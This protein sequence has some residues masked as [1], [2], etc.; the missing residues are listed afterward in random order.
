MKPTSYNGA[1]RVVNLINK[2]KANSDIVDSHDRPVH[3]EANEFCSSHAQAKRILIKVAMHDEGLRQRLCE[4]ELKERWIL[5][6]G[7]GVVIRT[8][9]YR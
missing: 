3:P 2:G 6:Q 9:S 5:G 8:P 7:S 4:K 1:S